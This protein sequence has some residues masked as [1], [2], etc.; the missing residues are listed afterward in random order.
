MLAF[1]S[2]IPIAVACGANPPMP[3]MLPVWAADLTVGVL[4]FVAKTLKLN[5]GGSDVVLDDLAR[6]VA[7]P[8][9]MGRKESLT[10]PIAN[11]TG[12][13][14][15]LKSKRG[16]KGGTTTVYLPTIWYTSADGRECK[17]PIVEWYDRPSANALTT[18]IALRI[19][20]RRQAEGP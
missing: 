15:E 2:I 9:T 8:P 16:S 10:I 20:G 14:V 7:L 17:Q 3:V 18:W 4:V 12:F 6:T 11:I 1:I 13:N 5:S 19:Q